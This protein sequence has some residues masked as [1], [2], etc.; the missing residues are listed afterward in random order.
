MPRNIPSSILALSFYLI[1]LGSFTPNAYSASKCLYISSYH[2]GYTWS[3]GVE[4]GIRNKLDGH[5]EIR[6]FNMDT[7]RNKNTDYIQI[8]AAAVKRQ[9]D[10]WQPD[11]VITSDDNAAKYVIQQFYKN[12]KTPFVFCGVN[13]TV[14]EYGFPYSNVTGMIE[15]APLKVMLSSAVKYSNGAH[16]AVYIGADTLTEKKNLKHT[17]KASKKLGIELKGILVSNM[18]DWKQAYEEAQQSGFIV[19][20]NH[21][22]INDWQA[23]KIE[24]F[25][26][27]KAKRLVVTNFDWM[28]PFS[29]IGFTKIAKEQGEWAAQAAIEILNGTSPADIPFVANRQW[30][31]WVNKQHLDN[32]GIK[33]PRKLLSKAKKL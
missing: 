23:D 10:D 20:G 28:M 25:A 17:L 6:Q 22:G 33:L 1:C 11:V 18:A 24:K 12:A 4:Q 5:C 14:K 2:Q 19:L 13:W 26:I 29:S 8:K 9:I 16:Q 32:I 21:S 31:L 15:V 7:K 30:D 3:D 27:E